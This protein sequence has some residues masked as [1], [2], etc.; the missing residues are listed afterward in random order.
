MAKQTNGAT[1]GHPAMDYP[2]HERT[3]ANF[4]RGSVWGIAAIIVVLVLMA[5]FLL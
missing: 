1:G 2:A 3:Y 5:W 4:I